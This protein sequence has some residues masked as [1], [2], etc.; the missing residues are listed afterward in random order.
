MKKLALALVL[1][2]SLGGCAQL[3]TVSTAWDLASKS[4]QNPVSKDDLYRVEAGIQI[5]FTALNTYK[6]ACVQGLADAKCGDNV[7]AIQAYT[8]QVPPYL[9]QLRS[10]VKNNDQVNASVVYNQLSQILANIRSEAA[11]RGV[12]MGA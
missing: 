5:A 7:A 3:Q 8:R 9:K 10:F 2:I 6:R 1:A 12:Q 11:Q 4:V